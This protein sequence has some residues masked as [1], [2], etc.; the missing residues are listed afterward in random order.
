MKTITVRDVITIVFIT[1][2]LDEELL[3]CT[4]VASKPATT[5]K[6]QHRLQEDIR[7]AEN[8]RGQPIASLESRLSQGQ[9]HQTHFSIR[10]E[11]KNHQPA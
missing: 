1:H 11:I 9:T 3:N 10:F 4:C 6:E 5:L 8:Q 2:D 7:L